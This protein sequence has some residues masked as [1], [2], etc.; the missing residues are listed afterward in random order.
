[1]V[2][3]GLLALS[4]KL[5]LDTGTSQDFR[6]CLWRKRV[7]VLDPGMGATSRLVY[8]ARFVELYL[9]KTWAGLWCFF[10][11]FLPSTLNCIVY[12]VVLDESRLG[13]LDRAGEPDLNF[14]KPH[15]TWAGSW[16]WY[17]Q[18][19]AL[20]RNTIFIPRHLRM[21]NS[22]SD[23]RML[24]LCPALALGIGLGKVRFHI[25]LIRQRG[26]GLSVTKDCSVLH[27]LRGSGF[28]S[29]RNTVFKF[30]SGK[31]V[32]IFQFI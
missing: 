4:W 31:F 7:W 15:G 6:S 17:A 24:L 29:Q 16:W 20:C 32:N 13:L 26:V 11:N 12:G 2:L 30:A 8:I 21:C 1:M 22:L 28:P 3:F 27:P 5:L 10:G 25:I 23:D 19:F 18:P 14:C 9:M